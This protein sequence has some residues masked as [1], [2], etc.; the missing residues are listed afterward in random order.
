MGT[1]RGIPLRTPDERP[2][3]VLAQQVSET[4]KL[5]S[6]GCYA[7]LLTAFVTLIED[8]DAWLRARPWL[9]TLSDPSA[10]RRTSPKLLGPNVKLSLLDHCS[11]LL[12]SM[13]DLYSGLLRCRRR[14]APLR[15][16]P[17]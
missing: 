1:G 6:N 2:S 8:L 7:D 5:L 3:F 11:R 12:R 14:T 10:R 4:R 17:W 16:R 13:L 15:C 9:T